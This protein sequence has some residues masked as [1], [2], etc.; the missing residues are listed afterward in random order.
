MFKVILAATLFLL[1]GGCSNIAYYAQSVE[2]H[3]RLMAKMRAIPDVV[4]DA[5]TDPALRKQLER[6]SAIREFAS[7]Q[8]ALPDN[9]NYRSYADL[10]RP[11]VVWNVFAAPEFSLELKQWCMLFVGCSCS[12]Q[13]RSGAVAIQCNPPTAPC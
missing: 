8:L 3:L 12:S 13:S 11:Y 6:V 4:T 7:H 10:G 1:I 5:A 9:E 2:G